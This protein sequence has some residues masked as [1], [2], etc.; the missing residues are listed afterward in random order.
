MNVTIADDKE[1][2]F[3]SLWTQVF[4]PSFQKQNLKYIQRVLLVGRPKSGKTSIA[5]R[6][7]Y[8]E[9]CRGGHPLF[10][11]RKADIYQCPPRYVANNCIAE[12]SSYVN[13]VNQH[14]A[15]NLHSYRPEVLSQINMKYFESG[16]DFYKY[17][18]VIQDMHVIPTL[19][20]VDNISQ[21][22]PSIPH[23]LLSPSGFNVGGQQL[24]MGI[25]DDLLCHVNEAKNDHIDRIRLLVTDFNLEN[26]IVS[27]FVRYMDVHIDIEKS[28]MNSFQLNVTQVGLSM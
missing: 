28:T 4:L 7:A 24:L 14:E 27:N 20:I 5:F 23:S 19:I 6:I 3:S 26:T 13:T 22:L 18:C 21:L 1:D 8:D 12:Q 10:V 16:D 2:E 9:A 11:S 17:L 15:S 25:L